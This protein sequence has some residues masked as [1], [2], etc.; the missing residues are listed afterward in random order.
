MGALAEMSAVFRSQMRR[1]LGL[2][3]APSDLTTHWEALQDMPDD[4][5]DAAVTRAQQVSDEFPSPKMLRLYA[6]QMRG[7]VVPLVQPEDRTETLDEPVAHELP[8]GKVLGFKRL[9]RYYC[10]DCSDCG[11]AQFWC[12][13]Y[14]PSD[15]QFVVAVRHDRT[16][17][18]RAC[19]RTAPHGAHVWVAECSCVSTNPEVQRRRERDRRVKRGKDD[20]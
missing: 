18:D 1:L 4:L 8:T 2:K 13:G 9:W 16:I 7:R 3:F 11:W 6:D 19:E 12:C 15:E 10:D 17:F 20:E 14:A 5:L